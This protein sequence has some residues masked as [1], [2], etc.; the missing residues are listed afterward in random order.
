MCTTVSGTV[1]VGTQKLSM[2]WP[3]TWYWDAELSLKYNGIK[4][5]FPMDQLCRALLS[6]RCLLEQD[7]H[8]PPE[9]QC[10]NSHWPEDRLPYFAVLL[11]LMP[12]TTRTKPHYYYYYYY[13]PRRLK[14]EKK[15]RPNI[16]II[17]Y[18]FRFLITLCIWQSCSHFCACAAKKYRR[19]LA[20]F[21]LW[22]F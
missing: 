11:F 5:K 16:P 18:C 3:H 6:C 20:F 2:S 10:L 1:T 7:V 9:N 19:N 17:H 12:T 21:A 15:H 8:H 14:T 4:T 13:I 22:K